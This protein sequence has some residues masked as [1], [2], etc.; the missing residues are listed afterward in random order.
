MASNLSLTDIRDYNWRAEAVL[1][2]II[3]GGVKVPAKNPRAP[4]TQPADFGNIITL[5]EVMQPSS[6]KA[7][8]SI[9]NLKKDTKLKCTAI[10]LN[11]TEYGPLEVKR[12]KDI[13]AK[14]LLTKG[15]VS[16]LEWKGIPQGNGNG[17]LFDE[18][19]I[20]TGKVV[21]TEDFGG[22][23]TAGPGPQT[24][25]QEQV[26]LKLFEILL[27]DNGYDPSNANEEKLLTD[28]RKFIKSD[29]SKIWSG[30][31]LDPKTG[32]SKARTHQ[33]PEVRKWYW[34]FFLQFKQIRD[35]SELP[36]NKF[37]VF[38]FDQFMDY[39]TKEIVI[40]GPPKGGSREQPWPI[41][42]PIS[43]KDSWN[44]ADIWL[45]NNKHT[46]YKA[47]MKALKEA[48]MIQQVNDILI[49]AYR[50][51][52]PYDKEG[53]GA[54]TKKVINP[55]IVGVS[56]KKSVAGSSAKTHEGKELHYD[57]VNLQFKGDV[58]PQ[59][60]FDTIPVK[61]P[62][63][64]S[65]KLF[66]N[67]TNTMEVEEQGTTKAIGLMKMGSGGGGAESNINLEYS[68]KGGG[69]M[70]GKIPRDILE[71]RLDL[72]WPDNPGLPTWQEALKSI[73]S[74]NDSSSIWNR[75]I[76]DWDKKF[77]KINQYVGVGNNKI[78]QVQGGTDL[79][80]KEGDTYK[81]VNYIIAARKTS[82]WDS[83]PKRY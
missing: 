50:G 40:P 1:D 57:L 8:G 18:V 29:L 13:L 21:K 70:L 35:A 28:F 58:L 25:Q 56:L 74:Q 68:Q 9:L 42:G 24:A 12:K 19:T 22:K 67:V 6:G 34:H 45:V 54:V 2:K 17:N 7:K 83:N 60:V 37:K 62:W 11:G 39:I 32:V 63:D 20:P 43:Q 49:N 64:K 31:A 15:A 16:S 77:K 55:I 27:K 26:T 46:H 80:N 48:K 51:K 23:T 79:F 73:P 53:T 14:K 3:N 38:D 72:S 69:A 4:I 65:K 78:F 82:D 36:N 44:P 52:K 59:V 75:K 81:F 47:T 33:N 10:I 61:I 76:D 66:T 71:E 5:F 41:F 30:L